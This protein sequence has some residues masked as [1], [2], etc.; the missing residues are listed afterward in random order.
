LRGL[1]QTAYQRHAFDRREI[2][3]GPAW[4]DSERF[5]LMALSAREHVVDSDGS[6]RQTWLMLRALLADRFKLRMRVESRSRPIYALVMA[7]PD[8]QLG[9]RLRRSEFDCAAIMALYLKGLP[10]ERPAC[11]SAS[12]PGR[13]VATAL[14]LPSVASLLSA[15]VDRVVID[16]TGLTGAFDL[17]LEATEIRPPGPFG[18]SYRPS[19]TKQS[20]FDGLP[21]QLGL[22]LEAMPGSVDVL[23]IDGAEKAP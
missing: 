23:V 16:R 9:P 3:G 15:S 20:I 19:D 10:P 6:T 22:K 17:E 11:S 14:T 2:E 1:I 5:D 18:P 7:T 4:I 13:L 21:Q 12:Y 8:Q